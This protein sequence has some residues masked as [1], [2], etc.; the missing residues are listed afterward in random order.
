F[1]EPGEA[2]RRGSAFAAAVAVRIISDSP[3]NDARAARRT[4]EAAAGPAQSNR[5]CPR[6]AHETPTRRRQRL[7]A[8]SAI[9]P[10]LSR[11]APGIR[12]PAH[13][14]AQCAQGPRA[15]SSAG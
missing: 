13:F 14:H 2:G 3:A 7:A 15:L 9:D 12:A 6:L 8:R 1:A 4:C 5:I 11:P 10:G